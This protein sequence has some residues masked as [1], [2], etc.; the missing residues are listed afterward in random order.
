MN[1]KSLKRYG[2]FEHTGLPTK[3]ETLKTTVRNLYC[4]FPYHEWI[5]FSATKNL[6][7]SFPN[8]KKAIN[9]YL[10]QKT[11]I[12]PLN[13]HIWWFL[14]RLW[15][16]ISMKIRFFQ[17]KIDLSQFLARHFKTYISRDFMELCRFSI[18]E[19]I[20]KLIKY[21]GLYLENFIRF[22]KLHTFIAWFFSISLILIKIYKIICFHAF[23]DFW[24]INLKNR[25]SNW[26]TKL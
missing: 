4:L 6:F 16:L 12:Q 9:L 22:L 26:Q 14:D 24:I 10:R 20:C 23:P 17:V 11:L 18:R 19:N 8:H 1:I 2:N 15:S 3:D 25:S 7:I 13:S 5:W 21:H